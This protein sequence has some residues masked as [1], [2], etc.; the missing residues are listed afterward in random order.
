MILRLLRKRPKNLEYRQLLQDIEAEKRGENLYASESV[1]DEPIEPQRQ[2]VLF[3]P[4][5]MAPRQG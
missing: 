1:A 2:G 5:K 3:D 4:N